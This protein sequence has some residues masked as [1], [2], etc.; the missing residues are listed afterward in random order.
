[1]RRIVLPT[2]LYSIGNEAFADCAN[3][4]S[5]T[6]PNSLTRIGNSA[7]SGCSKLSD[8]VIPAR[9]IEI[10]K[11][12][13]SGC[14][15]LTTIE[16]PDKVTRIG[17]KAF[18]NCS[19]LSSITCIGVPAECEEDCFA[20]VDKSIP[21]NVPEEYV[22]DYSN[23]K[24]WEDFTN[25][26]GVKCD[27][28]SG[29]LAYNNQIS[30][31]ITCKGA[32][33]I[34]G[35]GIIPA[36]GKP[37]VMEWDDYRDIIKKVVIS[38]GITEIGE[39][40]I[41]NLHNVEYLSLPNSLKIIGPYAFDWIGSA[42]LS[43]LIVPNGVTSIG[44]GAFTGVTHVSTIIVGFNVKTIGEYAFAEC[45]KLGPDVICL[46]VRPPAAG[47]GIF[48]HQ[49]STVD[50]TK[51][52]Y[53][54]A[55]SVSKYKAAKRWEEFTKIL[56]LDETPGTYI[57]ASG[58]FG[59]G[60]Y[61]EID[62]NGILSIKGKGE[63]PGSGK[64]TPA[65]AGKR[66]A[67]DDDSAPWADHLE[68]IWYIEIEAGITRIGDY[69]FYG[70]TNVQ[71]ITCYAATPPT[72]GAEAFGGIDTS[73]PLY[74]LESAEVAYKNADQ[75]LD[76]LDIETIEEIPTAIDEVEDKWANEEMRKCENT[77]LLRDGQLFIL[78]NGKTYTLQGQEVK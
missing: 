52:L 15:A 46:A 73:I 74:V 41:G 37:Y 66:N 2:Q 78:H 29:V 50:P 71:S 45:Y 27:I 76:F 40:T 31:R 18:N 20:G 23:A 32:L 47:M 17:E 49:G 35:N 21:L 61:W 25:I 75:W 8:F 30:W 33:M 5:V 72:C 22:E 14:A 16:I 62:S 48:S 24:E 9:V 10:G 38:E 65:S 55:Q 1:M 42:H 39:R 67:K 7:F 64:P 34:E 36:V 28:A 3:L 51:T 70:C 57:V 58:S 54:P 77:K 59:D 43:T 26:K 56:P 6:V 69:A 63:I 19:G 44:A 11:Y 12:A 4:L 60:L 53:V 13:F 68:D